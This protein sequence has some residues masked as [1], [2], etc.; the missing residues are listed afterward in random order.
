MIRKSRILLVVLAGLLV[1]PLL[2]FGQDPTAPPRQPGTQPVASGE[3]GENHQG[4]TTNLPPLG[5]YKRESIPEKTTPIPY[6]YV[7]E[8][9]VL[10]S[11]II[12]RTVDMRQ[13]INLPL[14]YPTV[15]MKD[16]KS[17]VQT[18]MEAI[19]NKEISA[20]EPDKSL[21]SPG[22]EFYSRLT[23]EEASARMGAFVQTETQTSMLTGRDT[24]ITTVQEAQW[25]DAR[26]LIIKEEWFFD[27]KHSRLQ[28]R[29]IGLCPVRVYTNP[30]TGQPERKLAFW[31][32][33]PECRK[34][35]SRTPVF[36]PKNDSQTISF[37]DLFFKRR[38]DSFILR[39]SNEYNNRAV[40]DYK[41]GGIPQLKESDRIK[42][43]LFIQE[44]DL[45]E[46]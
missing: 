9:D 22:D 42:N 31:V 12:W 6:T 24:T 19:L 33:Y 29:I 1:C 37:D 38:F 25:A 14:Y 15:T 13:K 17:L 43:D 18:L 2:A 30:Q 23:P 28:V 45:W 39:E 34:V 26:Q 46:Y 21:T 32:Y 4:D 11:K 20:Y 8:A 16:R 40:A 35:L 41:V 27:S 44:H 7:R 10:W 36:N 3:P 5:I